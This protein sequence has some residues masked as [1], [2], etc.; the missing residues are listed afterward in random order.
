MST[1]GYTQLVE[2]SG[3]ILQ[4][5]EVLN[6]SFIIIYLVIP[7]NIFSLQT[8]EVFDEFL[9]LK[10]SQDGCNSEA[11]SLLKPL[12]LRY[13]TPTELLRLFQFI[14]PSTMYSSMEPN[15]GMGS[16]T[17]LQQESFVWPQSVSRKSKY[18]LIG[19]SVNVDVVRRLIVYLF[20]GDDITNLLKSSAVRI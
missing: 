20:K 4:M 11:V 17:Q 7:S 9:A 14:Q 6:V 3:S 13:F 5:N 10:E 12:R 16:E 8:S 15:P 1:I 19:N 18:R 2:R